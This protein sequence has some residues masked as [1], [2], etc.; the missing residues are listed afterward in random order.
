[1]LFERTAS[2]RQ[3]KR[4]KPT[5]SGGWGGAGQEIE[6]LDQHHPDASRHPSSAE[7]GSLFRCLLI[8]ALLLAA[9]AP[10][11]IAQGTGK[12]RTVLDGVFTAAQ[13]ERGKAAYAANC[14]SCHME[15]LRGQAGPALKGDQF[16]DNW[17]EDSVKTLF[18][19]IQTRMPQ[20]RAGTLEEQTYVDILAHILAANEFP[21]GSKELTAAE[22]PGIVLVGKDG[23]APIPKFALVTVVGCLTKNEEEW[24]L[25][26]VSAPVRTHDEKPTSQEVQASAN[27][28]LGTGGY[29]LVYIDSLRPAF[30]PERHAGHKLHAQGYLLSNDKGEGLSVT[31]LEAVGSSCSD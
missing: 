1:M 29:R 13:A 24:R 14:S 5:R 23:P 28:P 6:F 22:I 21:A 26:K 3:L 27:K 4:G 7:E 8:L 9:L 11:A 12:Q 15:D 30:V 10:A 2:P 16:M 18:S 31:W 17:R 25:D 20:R 19:Y